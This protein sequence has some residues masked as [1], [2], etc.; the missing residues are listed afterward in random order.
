MGCSASKDE[1]VGSLSIAQ[2][3]MLL[4]EFRDISSELNV[5]RMISRTIEAIIHLLP[6]ERASVFL[7]DKV[8][9]VMQ[10]FNE[11]DVQA[12]R[13]SG[14]S[15]TAVAKVPDAAN[16]TEAAAEGEDAFVRTLVSIPLDKGIAGAAY[17]SRCTEI[18]SDAQ[19]D[20][21]FNR[22]IDDKT[23]FRTRNIICV[24]V[25]L[26]HSGLEEL[27][28]RSTVRRPK[29]GTVPDSSA[30]SHE[31]VA[32]LQALNREGNFVRADAV[33]LE[34]FS[35]M[36]AGVIAR[37]TLVEAAV[38]E[39]RMAAALLKV[40]E[41]VNSTHNCRLKALSIM[42]AVQLGVDCTRSAFILVDEVHNEQVRAGA[43]CATVQPRPLPCRTARAHEPR[44]VCPP[45][46]RSAAHTRRFVIRARRSSSRW[47]RIPQ[48]SD[49]R[50]T[51]GCRGR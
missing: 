20:P 34:A 1:L 18:V 33:V 25:K 49:C 4:N 17:A 40:A 16:D 46:R 51:R 45:H 12:S 44:A 26:Y 47:T 11:I 30:E 50:S 8:N 27:D 35:S 6:V 28:Q 24:P 48:G 42:K 39:K 43:G 19:N 15:T 5:D 29:Q 9:G 32:V 36:L 21:R 31:V 38:R 13:V 2:R 23:G 14:K 3:D 41:S 22:T 37:S 10:T 7:V